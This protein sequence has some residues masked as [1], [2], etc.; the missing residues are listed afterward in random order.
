M[1]DNPPPIPCLPTPIFKDRWGDGTRGRGIGK[2]SSPGTRRMP[3]AITIPR[4]GWN[5]DEGVFAGWLKRD[6]EAVRA[7]EPL[8][9][10]EGEKATQDVEA[11]DDGVLSIPPGAPGVGDRV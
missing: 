9:S 7:G 3:I 1:I 5:M 2:P 6:G 10:L 11:I 8:F 4:L